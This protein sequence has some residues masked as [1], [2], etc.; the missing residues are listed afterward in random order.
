MR[1]QDQIGFRL[2]DGLPQR[3]RVAVRRVR[4][5][6]F[7]LDEQNFIELGRRKFAGQRRDAFADDDGSET[8]LRFRGNLLR[9]GQRL[10]AG[11]VPLS[12]ALFGDEENVHRLGGSAHSTRA[13]C[14]NFSS[15]FAAASFGVPVRNSVFLVFTGT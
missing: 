5:E 7:V 13:S 1:Q 15:S 11:L 6:Q 4:G 14:F 9:R 12:F 8:A 3:D 10:K 2:R